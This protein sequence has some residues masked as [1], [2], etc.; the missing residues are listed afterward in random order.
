MTGRE[1]PHHVLEEE[2]ALEPG[3]G[4]CLRVVQGQRL[5]HHLP[6]EVLSPARAP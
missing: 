6:G 1:S 2:A 4:V 3:T 5:A